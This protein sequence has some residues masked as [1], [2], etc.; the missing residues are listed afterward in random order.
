MSGT[1]RWDDLRPRILSA[2]VL[3]AVGLGA[4]WAG[5]FWFI[6]LVVLAAG[7]MCWELVAMTGARDGLPVMLG[8]F[9]AAALYAAQAFSGYWPLPLLAFAVLV[10]TVAIPRRRLIWFLYAPVILFG[11]WG[12]LLLRAAGIEVLLWLI[13]IVVA[14]DVAGY[15]G[16][17][18]L[19]GPKFW[20]RL[21][22]R[23]TWSGTLAGWVVAT[24]I[25]IGIWLAGGP[26]AAIVSSP[27]TAFAAQMGDIAESAVK[28]RLGVKDASNLIPGHGG[29]LDRFDALLGAALA[30]L[31]AWLVTGL[32]AAL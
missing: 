18:L 29:L 21:S 16:G 26:P 24:L 9:G 4:I 14:S 5:G 20:P 23:K 31:V 28:R 32:L 19:G 13:A 22:P 8:L 11:A 27:L 1:S 3:A 2:A 17:R 15:F 12:V 7:V 10:G 6:G 30:L 25:G